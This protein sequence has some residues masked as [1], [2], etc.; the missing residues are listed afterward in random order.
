MDD[1][2]RLQCS[3]MFMFLIHFIRLTASSTVNAKSHKYNTF[4]K[5]K[6]NAYKYFEQIL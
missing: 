1:V 2:G 6:M 5:M 4:L 3:E